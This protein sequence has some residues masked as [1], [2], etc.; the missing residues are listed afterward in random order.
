MNKLKPKRFYSMLDNSY[1]DFLFNFM[2]GNSS[3]NSLLN[4]LAV[5]TQSDLQKKIDIYLSFT[6]CNHM[7]AV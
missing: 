7:I 3:S 2:F 5:I 1:E 4:K 6:N